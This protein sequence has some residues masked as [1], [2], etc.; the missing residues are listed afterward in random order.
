MTTPFANFDRITADPK[1]LG[2]K[3]CIRGLRVPVQLVLKLL[4]DY[5]DRADLFADYPELEPEDLAQALAFAS[6]MLEDR[7]IAF[8][9]SAA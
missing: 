8:D 9:S 4:A 6:S 7:F 2:G 1:V 5:P 3:P